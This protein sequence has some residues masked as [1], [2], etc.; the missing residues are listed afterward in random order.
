MT[1]PARQDVCITTNFQ[2]KEA[3]E[4]QPAELVGGLDL[5]TTTEVRQGGPGTPAS[6]AGGRAG[7]NSRKG[8]IYPAQSSLGEGVGGPTEMRGTVRFSQPNKSGKGTPS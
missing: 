3:Q 2:T 7:F 1:Q 4:H 5:W 6:R 8:R